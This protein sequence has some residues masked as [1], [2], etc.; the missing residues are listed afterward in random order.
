M[1]KFDDNDAV[2]PAAA[3]PATDNAALPDTRRRGLLKAGLGASLMP[4]G[5]SMLLAACGGGDDDAPA[6]TP[7]PAPGT[8]ATPDTPAPETPAV[9]QTVSSF[10]VAV[11]P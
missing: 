5:A 8:P 2:K 10:A 6:A 11:L 7:A 4:M 1:T 3:V 9:P